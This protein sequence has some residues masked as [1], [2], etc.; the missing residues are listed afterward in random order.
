MVST[1]CKGFGNDFEVIPILNGGEYFA[2]H[3]ELD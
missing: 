1:H 3:K 2:I